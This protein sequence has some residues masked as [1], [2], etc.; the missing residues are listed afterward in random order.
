MVQ[1]FTFTKLSY[2][3]IGKSNVLDALSFGL[4]LKHISKKHKHLS[5]L[6]YREET[7]N[8][9]ENRREMSV[10]L[11]FNAAL[12]NGQTQDIT[13]KRMINKNGVQEYFFNGNPMIAEEYLSKINELHLNINNFCA[14]QG[15]LE[16]LCFK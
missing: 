13:L 1:V 9:R 5:E 7:E 11:N 16:E 14:Y 6:I 3:N 8:H 2:I 15:K 10:Q 12:L 4:L